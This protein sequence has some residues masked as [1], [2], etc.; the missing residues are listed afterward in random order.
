MLFQQY[1]PAPQLRNY[2]KN[3]WVL[4]GDEISEK[5]DIIVPDGCIE[6]IFHYGSPYQSTIAG[7]CLSQPHALVFG[8]LKNAIYLQAT[9][10]TGIFAIRFYPWG[11]YPFIGLPAKEFTGCFLPATSLF[12]NQVNDI[13]DQLQQGDSLSR[14]RLI[15]SFLLAVLKRQKSKLV[16]ETARISPV[17]AM[18]EKTAGNISVAELAAAAN[19]SI[20]Q[21][22]RLTTDITGLAPKYLARTARLQQFF[23][24][25][26][27]GCCT[28]TQALHGSGYYDQAHFIRDFKDMTGCIPT[29]FFKNKSGISDLMLQ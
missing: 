28:L 26:E 24:L 1:N 13:T 21:F 27:Y 12:G 2:I 14:V 8:Q 22:N 25:F 9:G 5:P 19:M 18:I 10:R 17:I 7:E 15:E 20:R 6:M 11:L 16:E 23:N 4:E 3:Y 29:E